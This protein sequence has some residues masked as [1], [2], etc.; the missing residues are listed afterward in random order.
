MAVAIVPAAGRSSRMGRPKLLMPYGEGTILGSTVE[1]LRGGGVVDIVLV[2]QPDDQALS[3]WAETH[4]VRAVTNLRADDGMLTSIW[5]GL[6]VLGG[7][8]ALIAARQELLVCPGDLPRLRAET[9]AALVRESRATTAGLLVPRCGSE[10][11]HPLIVRDDMLRRIAGLD[12]EIGLR[13]LRLRHPEST[14]EVEVGD[15]GV[16]QDIDTPDD[17]ARLA[18]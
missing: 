14:V 16:I 5:A 4:G 2:I 9:V 1:A 3:D 13:E 8:E 17:Y 12:P 11:G 15:P 6:E 18:T 10:R 7:A